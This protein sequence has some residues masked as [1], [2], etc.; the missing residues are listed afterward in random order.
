MEKMD[1]TTRKKIKKGANGEETA[2]IVS[3]T[4]RE[5]ENGSVLSLPKDFN[6]NMSKLCRHVHVYNIRH[7]YKTLRRLRENLT[8]KL[9]FT[10]IFQKTSMSSIIKKYRACTLGPVRFK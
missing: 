4:V 10:W 1:N 3:M 7:Q 2:S 6:E 9:S 8:D 5:E